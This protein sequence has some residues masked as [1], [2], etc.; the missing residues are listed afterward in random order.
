MLDIATP[1]HLDA[2][3]GLLQ[4]KRSEEGLVSRVS[5]QKA[6]E[7]IS[8]HIARHEC[9][10][11]TEGAHVVAS[12]AVYKDMFWDSEDLAIFDRWFYVHPKHRDKGHAARMIEALKDMARMMR[13]PLILSVGTTPASLWRLQYFKKR[14][15]PFGGS[16]VFDPKREAA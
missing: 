3:Y 5:E 16:F 6:R 1:D 11:G 7:A 12:V 13:S 10:I 4:V 2:I 9:L 8:G 15:T 14:L